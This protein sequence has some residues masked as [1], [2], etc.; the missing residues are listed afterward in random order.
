MSRVPLPLVPNEAPSW[1][2]SCVECARCCSYVAVGIN[3]PTTPHLA[4]D[5]VWHL[6]HPKVVVYRDGAGHWSVLFETRCRHL[7]EDLRCG[8]YDERPHICRAFDANT[9]EANSPHGGLVFTRPEEFLAYLKKRRPKLHAR[10][11]KKHLPASLSWGVLPSHP[12]DPPAA[13]RE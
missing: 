8:I 9:C 1:R 12:P 7:G 11:A 13:A 10:I 6:H 2:R 3:G 5:I 4:T